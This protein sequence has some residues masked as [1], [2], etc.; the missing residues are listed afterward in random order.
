MSDVEKVVNCDDNDVSENNPESS[1]LLT[2]AMGKIMESYVNTA[3][4]MS[5]DQ[6][7]QSI[8][9]GVPM[10]RSSSTEDSDY[11]FLT[12]AFAE[13]LIGRDMAFYIHDDGAG[14]V[15]KSRTVSHLVPSVHIR[16]VIIFNTVKKK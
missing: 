5:F 12:D 2:Q 1:E 13:D 10:N 4:G 11:S 7:S 14:D 16:E 9:G 3:M 6:P 15:D 8:T